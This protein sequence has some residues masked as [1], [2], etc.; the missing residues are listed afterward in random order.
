[1]AYA[2]RSNNATESRYSSYE[3]KCLAT[4]WAV[5]H[6]MCYLFG[7]QFTLVSD[8]QPLKWLMESDKLIGK[9]ARWAFI[10]HEYDFQV[11]HI[12]GVT[13]LDADGLNR[14][15][16]TNQEDN[17][18]ARWH[19]EVDDEMVLGWHASTLLCLLVVDSSTEGH[20]TSYSSQRVNGQSSDLEVGDGN[21]GH[22]D[23]HDDTLVLEFL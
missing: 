12:P 3:G 4:V 7:T 2:S 21:T 19:G 11:V 16:C 1:M 6:F 5:A 17:T 18:R 14:N 20:M 9:L 13:N 15:P 22:H 10:L 23:V 8:H